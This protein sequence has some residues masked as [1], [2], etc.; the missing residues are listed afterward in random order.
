LLSENPKKSA[1]TVFL[2]Y[3]CAGKKSLPQNPYSFLDSWHGMPS[4]SADSLRERKGGWLMSTNGA[5]L[6]AKGAVNGTVDVAQEH[7]DSHE[8]GPISWNGQNGAEEQMRSLDHEERG[9]VRMSVEESLRQAEAQF[10]SVVNGSMHGIMIRSGEQIQFANPTCARIF[11]YVG[12][13]EI[14]GQPWHTLVAPEEL[15]VHQ[16]RAQACLRG[17]TI[18]PLPG[19]Q[20][21]RKDGKRIWLE[22]SAHPFLWNGQPAILAFVTDITER[23]LAEAALRQQQVLLDQIIQ[24]IPLAVFWKDKNG[25]YLGCNQKSA[26]D[27]GRSSPAEIIGRTDFEA[28]FSREEAE[29]YRDCDRRVVETGQPLLNI[30]ETQLRADGTRATLLTSKVPLCDE[31]GQ[32]TGVLGIYADITERKRVEEKLRRSEERYR[33]LVENALD[34]IYSHDIEGNISGWNRAGETTLGYPQEEACRLNLTALLAP[35]QL[36]LARQMTRR[37]LTDGRRTVYRLEVLAK[38][39]H[40]VPMEI[41][42][43][44][45]QRPGERPLILGIA[46]DLTERERAEQE[47]VAM[48]Q[49]LQHVVAS[50]PAVLYALAVKGSSSVPTWVS[51]NMLDLLGYTVEE[52]LEPS[53]WERNIHPDDRERVRAESHQGL[54]EH[55][56]VSSEYRFRRKSGNYRWIQ[57]EMRALCD[58]SGH[59]V[60]IIGSWTDVTER[61][62]L[63]EQYRQ[64]QKMEGIGRLAGGVAHDFNNLLTVINGYS[65]MLLDRPHLDEATKNSLREIYRA[66]SR[67]AELTNQ[68]LAFSRKQILQLK[69]LDLNAVLLN[70]EKMLRRLLGEDIDLAVI[71]APQLAAVMAD[72]GQLDQVI[73]NLSVNARDAMPRGGNLTLETGNVFLDKEYVETCTELKPGPY[74]MLAVSDTGSGMDKETQSRIFEPFFTTKEHGKGTGLGLATVFGIIKQSDGHIAVYSEVGIG[75]TFKIYLPAVGPGLPTGETQNRARVLPAGTETLLLVEDEDGVRALAKRALQNC[76]Y[77]VLEADQGRKALEVA[78]AHAEAIHLLVTDV[79]MPGM[80]GR[81]VAE[82]LEAIK[83]GIKVLYVSGYTDDAVIRHGIIAAE[84]AF[85][86]KPFTAADLAIKVRKTLDE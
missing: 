4:E 73:V 35:D 3:Y 53:F 79:V 28:S 25:V 32:R 74:V 38:D 64:S 65:D 56:R 81:E 85:L 42:S 46:R 9:A 13:E 37:K 44:I 71:P 1:S 27:M 22:S 39:G 80:N 51:D 15:P 63:E 41:C 60:E 62:D 26:R 10:R 52:A 55:G 76:G 67:A 57:S 16:A 19:W 23:K 30:E 49:R 43:Q 82:Q 12:P 6:H 29:F 40:T 68:L 5:M 50:S 48:Q 66:G 54:L 14:I 72:R 34:V 69:L 45:V 47:L 58:A 36:E 24:N 70:S 59:A 2:G 75:T 83:P 20:G 77:T 86:Q 8:A 7:A 21:L 17:E 61:K 84:R 11:G 78:A 31:N 18:P 33:E